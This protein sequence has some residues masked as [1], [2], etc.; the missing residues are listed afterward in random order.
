MNLEMILGIVIIAGGIGFM[1]Y[2]VCWSRKTIDQ[3][4]DKDL[5]TAREIV[6]NFANGRKTS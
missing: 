6:G 1:T 4:E 3:I 5:N 2:L